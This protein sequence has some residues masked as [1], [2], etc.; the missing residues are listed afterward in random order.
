MND[1]RSQVLAV[2]ATQNSKHSQKSVQEKLHVTQIRI[3]K[4]IIP[5]PF[6]NGISRVAKKYI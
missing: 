6:S 2:P 1:D 3:P 4:K 5:R